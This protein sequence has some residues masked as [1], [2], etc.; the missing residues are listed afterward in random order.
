M[1][2]ITLSIPDEMHQEMKKFPAIKWSEAARRGISLQLLEVQGVVQGKE[3][4]KHLPAKTRSN[5]EEISKISKAD[6]QRWH[7]KM[8]EKEWT[9]AKSLTRV[10]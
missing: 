3:W 2:H 4:L 10:S 6:W 8:R 5:I 1:A 7:K 9:R